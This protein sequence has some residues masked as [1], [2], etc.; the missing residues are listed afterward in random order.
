MWT[1]L[2]IFIEFVTILLLFYVLVF[3]PHGKW[4]LTQFLDQRSRNSAPPALEG[5]VLTTGPP[6]K[7]LH[8]LN[9]L[10]VLN[11]M[12]SNT[13]LTFAPWKSVSLDSLGKW[14]TIQPTSQVRSWRSTPTSPLSLFS[15]PSLSSEFIPS[16][17]FSSC[18]LLS[19]QNHRH[20]SLWWL[21]QLPVLP[22]PINSPDM[23]PSH[24]YLLKTSLFPL[25]WSSMTAP[26]LTSLSYFLAPPS[27]T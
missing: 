7:S 27:L 9:I 25:G 18:H 16:L 23:Q 24:H 14:H 6:G 3:W 4:D 26:W 20:C 1:I 10:L 21:Q 19:L 13:K 11:L 22:F 5:K 15:C 17:V 12:C 8:Y 2:K